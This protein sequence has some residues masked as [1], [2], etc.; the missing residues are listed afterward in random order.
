MHIDI[1]FTVIEE[2]RILK[3]FTVKKLNQN[4]DFFA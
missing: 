2:Q 1:H 4:T 3:T